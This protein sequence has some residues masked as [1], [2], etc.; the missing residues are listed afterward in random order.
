MDLHSTSHTPLQALGYDATRV[1]HAYSLPTFSFSSTEWSPL[2]PPMQGGLLARVGLS[3]HCWG[4]F[5]WMASAWMQL[6]SSSRRASFTRRWRCNKERPSNRG[7]TSRTRKWDSEPGGTACMWLSLWTSRCC[8]SSWLVSLVRMAL[9]TGRLGSGS[10]RGL[11][12]ARGRLKAGTM[13]TGRKE[14]RMQGNIRVCGVRTVKTPLS[15]WH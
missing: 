12:W 15:I 14:R 2:E 5:A 11:K 7:L 3:P 13:D 4:V 6:L 1:P 10:M 9:S 8:G